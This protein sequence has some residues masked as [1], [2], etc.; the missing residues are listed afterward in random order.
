MTEP[1]SLTQS[2]LVE[3][4]LKNNVKAGDSLFV[5]SSLSRFGMVEG[6][7]DCVCKALLKAVGPGGTVLMPAFTFENVKIENPVL[8][9]SNSP[10]CTGKITEVFRSRYAQSRS[11]HLTHSV[12][13]AGK[14][15]LLYT[16]GHSR[17]AFDNQS[18]LMRHA[19]D[20]GKV[21]LLG[22]DYNA[23]TLFHC[24]EYALPVPYMG[25]EEKPDG[26]IIHPGG[27][28]KPAN[29]KVHKPSMDY[30]FNR[31]ADILEKNGPVH[32]FKCANAICRI[33]SAMEVF[34]ML[35][36]LLKGDS[37]A[38]TRTGSQRVSM[39]VSGPGRGKGN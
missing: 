30:D 34:D 26:K 28:V 22:V 20:G 10:S 35:M 15:A 6:G 14:K 29:A 9:L 24:A 16:G 33:F 23:C 17:D 27:S 39:P 19:R 25:M 13:A 5:H 37:F 4:L 21:L 8:D 1:A 2:T 12:C 7:A 31:A 38:L 11:D 36:Q 3:I 32:V 18:P